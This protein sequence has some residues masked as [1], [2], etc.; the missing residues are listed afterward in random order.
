[1]ITSVFSLVYTSAPNGL[2]N[3]REWFTNQMRICVNGTANQMRI[4]VNGTANQMRICV[5]VTANQMCICVNGTA[6]LH[7]AIRERFAY[8]SP[9]T[10]IGW[11]SAQTQRELD[12]PGVLCSPQV[13]GKLINRAPSAN[14]LARL[15]FA[16]VYWAFAST[17]SLIT[18]LSVVLCVRSSEP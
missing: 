4:C 1:M 11:F 7:C 16:R 15:W 6:N 9:R 3:A 17:I 5:N 8:H 10:E 14:C 2:Q 13:R 12:V 18:R